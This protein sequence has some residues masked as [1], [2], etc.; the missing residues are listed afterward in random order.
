MLTQMVFLFS[1]LKTCM[2]MHM[3]AYAYA[4]EAWL[5]RLTVFC[6]WCS[7]KHIYSWIHTY[8]HT[9]IHTWILY[10]WSLSCDIS[11]I[12]TGTHAHTYTHIYIHI[13]TG[14]AWILTFHTY[15]HTH[16][17]T[18]LHSYMHRWSLVSMSNGFSSSWIHTHIHTYT[19]IY[20]HICTGGAW[21]LR[22]TVSRLYE[23]HFGMN[24]CRRSHTFW[25]AVRTL[26]Q[27]CKNP[28][29]TLQESCNNVAKI[30]NVFF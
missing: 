5:L 26:Q 14:G 29:T 3:H 7:S 22:Q 27:R 25:N 18:H 1:F 2:H 6:F 4:H 19:H 13:Y 11:Y 20:M 8:T 10:R 21:F 16:I 17:H 24:V 9:Y 30:V 23:E 28:A 15:I 12:H